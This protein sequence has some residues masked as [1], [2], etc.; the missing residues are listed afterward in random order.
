MGE[1]APSASD[2][3]TPMHPIH[4]DVPPSPFRNRLPVT[5]DTHRR[6]LRPHPRRVKA[7]AVRTES[8]PA[9]HRRMTGGALALGVTRGA[10]L[11]TLT[12]RLPMPQAE[13]TK[14]IVIAYAS[15]TPG[16][17][18]P[19][20]LMTALAELRRVMTI[21]AIGGTRI[22]CAGVPC[23]KVL[24][25]IPRLPRAIGAMTRETGTALMTRFA[26]IGARVRL[27]TM[28]LAKRVRVCRRR[29]ARELRA[30]GASDARRR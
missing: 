15:E 28:A 27:R 26:A 29:H 4:A 9:P 24:R 30:R 17:D 1:W 11:E 12:R 3:V 23:D 20:L 5:G 7:R 22:R 18:Q 21:I 19:R 14:R 25:M 2:F 13:P 10:G 16:R 8:V 6:I